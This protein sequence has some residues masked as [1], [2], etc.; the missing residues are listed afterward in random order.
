MKLELTKMIVFFTDGQMEQ[1]NAIE[2]EIS[3]LADFKRDG[4]EVSIPENQVKS[5]RALFNTWLDFI[6][7]DYED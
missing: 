2:K 5:I 4:V 7:I 6:S 3:Q 1:I